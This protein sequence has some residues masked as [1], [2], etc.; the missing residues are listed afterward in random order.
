MEEI[1]SVSVMRFLAARNRNTPLK[2]AKMKTFIVSYNR[3]FRGRAVA[4]LLSSGLSDVVK[5]LRSF[6]LPT[7]PCSACSICPLSCLLQSPRW[8]QPRQLILTYPPLKAGGRKECPFL[9][10]ETSLPLDLCLSSTL[11]LGPLG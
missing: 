4:G 9:H 3:E 11:P 1:A 2:V 6:D 5:D 8:P 7:L 10:G